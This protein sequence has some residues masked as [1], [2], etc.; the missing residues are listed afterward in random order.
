MHTNTF[1]F[2]LM[3]NFKTNFVCGMGPS[4]AS[5]KSTHAS[6]MFKMR[7][8]SPPKSAC[9][10]VSMRLILTPLYSR[11]A[12]LARIVIPRSASKTLLSMDAKAASSLPR[13]CFMRL[14]ESVVLPWSTCA[15]MAM[16]RMSSRMYSSGE[17][18]V[19][20]APT[21]T[22]RAAMRLAPWRPASTP[23][24]TVSAKA[25]ER[26]RR[27]FAL[28]ATP[29]TTAAATDASATAGCR[30]PLE[31]SGSAAFSVPLGACQAL[32]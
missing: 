16:L 20:P 12:F 4:C 8:T 25:L 5:T 9:P 19:N 13:V 31:L 10:G 27:R 28:A 3:A 26:L 21:A 11:A 6:A 17:I 32:A 2:N 23:L 30:A 18:R 15:M 7:S 24:T 22:E 29:P 14:F 1:L